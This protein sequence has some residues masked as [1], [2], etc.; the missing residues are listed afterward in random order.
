M[1]NDERSGRF[2]ASSGRFYTLHKP[3]S[4]D[5]IRSLEPVRAHDNHAEAINVNMD[6][7]HPTHGPSRHSSN[8]GRSWCKGTGLADAKKTRFVQDKHAQRPHCCNNN[9][10]PASPVYHSTLIVNAPGEREDKAARAHR[11]TNQATWT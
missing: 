10:V 8:G 2:R 1:N 5:K 4:Y 11:H 7:T 6:I 3:I 9:H